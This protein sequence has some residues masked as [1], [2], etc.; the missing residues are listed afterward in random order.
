MSMPV[1]KIKEW[2]DTLNDDDEIGVDED[3]MALTLA[4]D[5]Y[6]DEWLEIGTA[7]S[8]DFIHA[9]DAARRATRRAR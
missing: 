2:L 6:E 4:D 7:L 8:S 9:L 5:R 3:G 1:R